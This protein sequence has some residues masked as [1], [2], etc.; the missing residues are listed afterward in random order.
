MSRDIDRAHP[1]L[2]PLIPAFIEAVY[3]ETGCDVLITCVDRSAREQANLYALGRDQ[4]TLD[5]YGISAIAKPLARRV[6]NAKPGESRHNYMIGELAA[7]LAFDFVPIRNGKL[8]WGTSGDGLDEDP[9]DD[10]HDDLELWQRC[11]AIGERLGMQWAGRWTGSL[12]EYAHLQ[13]DP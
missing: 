8:V 6:T 9:D 11:G 4:A 5:A 7:S 10:R 1:R 2:Q 12:R 13:I 3:A